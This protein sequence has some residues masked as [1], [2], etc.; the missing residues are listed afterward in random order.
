MKKTTTKTPS[1]EFD[2]L[3]ESSF[4][5]LYEITAKTADG[6]KT[7]RCVLEACRAGEAREIFDSIPEIRGLGFEVAEIKRIMHGIYWVRS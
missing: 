6:R 4:S 2:T 1:T 7:V 5:S 3:D